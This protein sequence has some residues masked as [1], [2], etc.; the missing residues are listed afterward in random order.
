M[1]TK[2]SASYV[3]LFGK[4]Q[5]EEVRKIELQRLKIYW[6]FHAHRQ[7]QIRQGQHLYRHRC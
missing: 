6:N 7:P 5:V 1:I 4:A 3:M 2:P